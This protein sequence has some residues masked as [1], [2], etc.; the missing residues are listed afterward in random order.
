MDERR[1]LNRMPTILTHQRSRFITQNPGSPFL[2]VQ[3]IN[4][5][6]YALFPM[7]IKEYINFLGPFYKLIIYIWSKQ[8]HCEERPPERNQ[9]E[10]SIC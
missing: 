3:L 10:K 9:N 1:F 6:K 5:I 2:I 4:G 8:K 7:H